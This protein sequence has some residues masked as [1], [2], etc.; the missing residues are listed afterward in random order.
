MI[1]TVSLAVVATATTV[2]IFSF[3]GVVVSGVNFCFFNWSN[4]GSIS[5]VPSEKDVS[6][7]FLFL[8]DTISSRTGRS[9]DIFSVCK[10]ERNE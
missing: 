1:G 2:D 8:A 3:M 10:K 7:S 5:S 4:D 6:S 9:D